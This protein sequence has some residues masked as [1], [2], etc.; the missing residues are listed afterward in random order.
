MAGLHRGR[1]DH[2]YQRHG[3]LPRHRRGREHFRDGFV[4]RDQHRQDRA[5]RPGRGCRHYGGDGSERDGYRLVQ[6]RFRAEGVF[7]GQQRVAGLHGRR[8]DGR[9]RHGVFPRDRRSGEHLRSDGLHG[10][11]HRQ[12]GERIYASGRRIPED[13]GPALGEREIPHLRQLWRHHRLDLRVQRRQKGRLWLDQRRCFDVQQR[14]SGP[15][16]QRTDH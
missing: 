7:A 1:S 8:A 6:R 2:H 14:Q 12:V 4:C 10:G 5:G 15:A 11:E 16:G 9:K 13:H 3:G